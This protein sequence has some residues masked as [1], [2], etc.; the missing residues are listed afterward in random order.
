MVIDL[1]ESRKKI[2]EIDK[3]IVRLF[4]KRMGVA[5]DVA[6]YKRSTGKKVLDPKRDEEKI[7][8]LRALGKDEFNKMGIEDLFRQIMSISRKYQYQALG[9]AVNEIPFRQVKSLDADADTR[10]VCFGEHGAFTEQ[11]I[12]FVK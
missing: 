12:H 11:A 7:E 3:E 8:S 4:Q 9:P 10:V 1:A 6:A 5:T 2:D